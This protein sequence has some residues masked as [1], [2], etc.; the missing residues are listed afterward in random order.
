MYMNY[1]NKDI[2]NSG[3]RI[4]LIHTHHWV[5][6]VSLLSKHLLT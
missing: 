1:S 3:L 4:K 2:T 5:Y 6:F